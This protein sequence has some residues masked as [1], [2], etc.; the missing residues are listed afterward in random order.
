MTRRLVILTEIISPYRIPL[1]N[2][3]AQELELDPHVIFMSETDP[4]LRRWHVYKH[5]IRFSYEVLPSWRKR[6]GG[7]NALLNSGLYRALRS[8]SPDMIV[9]GG[10]SYVASWQALWWA[11]FQRTPFLL[12]SESCL[13]DRRKG[14]SLVESL[15]NQF[16]RNCNG[17][18]V[19]GRSARDYL[20][21][22]GVTEELVFTA[23]NAVDND[24]FARGA[25]AARQEES[26]YR[27]E[28]SLP[29][30]Y[31]LFVGRLEQEKGVF[32]LLA[33][34]ARME[35]SVRKDIGLV[36]VGDGAAR[37]K[38]EAQA[39]PISPGVVKFAG[40]AHQER[41]PAYYA[42]ADSLILPTYTDPW[43]LVVNEAMACS[44]PVIVSRVA[45]CAADLVRDRWNGMLVSAGDV[46]SLCNA[47]Q[48][49][50]SQPGLLTTM[51]AHSAE[52]I[53]HYS[54]QEWSAGLARA[55]DSI[56]FGHA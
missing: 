55:V 30:R 46:P 53:R 8:V 32:D 25:V 11:R 1:F 9:C 3:L 26:R 45:G 15:K 51:G 29:N 2:A 20:R 22:C 18:V 27:N 40:F 10:Y 35:G 7:Y 31:F 24:F 23:V 54:P 52:H 39:L 43:G 37:E 44:L 16:L 13:Q 5:D 28:L 49:I 17:F 34:Y 42:L 33:A 48:L 21:R 36:F 19:P 14:H 6:I 4:F 41:L 56:R 50:V 47:M 12:W 38:L